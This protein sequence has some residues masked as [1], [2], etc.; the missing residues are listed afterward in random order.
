MKKAITMYKFLDGKDYNITFQ[1]LDRVF[2]NIYIVNVEDNKCFIKD[3]AKSCEKLSI[4]K[5]LTKKQI[6]S[7]V[8]SCVDYYVDCSL[9]YP[10]FDSEF[11][12]GKVSWFGRKFE[13]DE[14]FEDYPKRWFDNQGL[15]ALN[16]LNEDQKELLLSIYRGK[17]IFSEVKDKCNLIGFSGE[18]Y[19]VLYP[20][21][22][23]NLTLI[24]SITSLLPWLGIP[25]NT[26]TIPKSNLNNLSRLGWLRYKPSGNPFAIK[27]VIASM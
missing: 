7:V 6:Y 18:K 1:I 12:N 17:D 10:Y 8:D 23:F 21:S 14:T 27:S 16:M 13:I 20:Y 11:K 26:L 19:N 24:K 22:L 9:L 3:L 4:F 2:A 25:V 5:D 15:K